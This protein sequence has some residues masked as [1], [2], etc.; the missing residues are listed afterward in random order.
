MASHIEPVQESSKKKSASTG[1]S[2]AAVA[3]TAY[4]DN[5]LIDRL[6]DHL[7]QF[8]VD[9]RYDSYTPIDH[10]VWRFV[11]RQNY[12]FLK[13]AAHPAYVD[14]L[15]K[16]GI[17]IEQIPGIEG[18]NKILGKIGWAAVT[19]D[20]FIPPAAFMEFQA[21]RILVIAADIRQVNHIEYTPAPDIIHE[22][23]GHAPIIADAEYA[24][25]L[26]RIGEVGAKAMSSRRDYE[27]YEAIRHLSI[28]KEQPDADPA[29]VEKAEKDVDDKQK[30]LG[31]PSEMARLSRLHWWTVEYGLIGTLENPKVYGA[32]LL[33]SIGESANCLTDKVKKLP[34]NIETAQ[35]PF[36]ITTQQ[37]HLF[38]TPD[39]RHLIDVLEEFA[40]D[41]AYR[42]GGQPGLEK[43][44]ECRNLCTYEYS[45]GLQVS[46]VVEESITDGNNN[47]IFVRTSGPTMLSIDD[48]VLPSHSKDTHATGFASPV[49]RPAGAAKPLEVMSD[50]ELVELGLTPRTACKLT[51]ETG[52]EI[53]GEF[54]EAVRKKNKVILLHFSSAVIRQGEIIL[55]E[56]AG[57]P[58]FMAVGGGIVS[59]Y[60]GAADKDSYQQDSL[61]PR[62]RTIKSDYT[63]KQ[64]ELHK[65]Y[66][67][68]RAI[69]EKKT[70]HDSLAEI[71]QRLKSDH[72]YD[73]L[74]A[75]EIL[76][77][78]AD[79]KL[80]P[81]LRTEI[82]GYLEQKKSAHKHL[83]AV[84]ERGLDLTPSAA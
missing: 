21:Y 35:Y 2:A 24:E 12:N 1:N 44:I 53:E 83:A 75:M 37:P 74:L 52:I 80:F 62:E 84:I 23:A 14:G 25:Y 10:A 11:M 17:G 79:E 40:D 69:R 39:F 6:P 66:Q 18:M 34:Y 71:W 29:E 28:L 22:A 33:S 42:T 26:R 61:V 49:G 70:P 63:P 55:Y 15:K 54:E 36:D 65:L 59:V 58:F 31:E 47:P 3:D 16:T 7:K 60:G 81:E 45:S 19:V 38:V 48:T 9:Q 46:G 56:S 64:R 82:H 5:P 77:I 13:D 50:R 67:R 27:L 78:L 41:M 32:G 51:F 57:K 73:W 8:I 30:N 20:G 68:V 43:A 72:E 76:E 4:D